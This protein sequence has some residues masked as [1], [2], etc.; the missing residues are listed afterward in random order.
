MFKNLSTKT[1]LLVFPILVVI[2]SIIVAVSY[3]TSMKYIEERTQIAIKTQDSVKILLEARITV[4]Q[5]MQ[6]STQDKKAIVINEFKKLSNQMLTL[7]D[8]FQSDRNKKVADDSIAMINEYVKGFEYISEIM[9]KDKTTNLKDTISH[10]VEVAQKLQ[11]SIISLNSDVNKT[12]EEA[13]NFLST[14]LALIGIISIIVFIGISVFISN[15]IMKSLVNVKEGLLSFFGFLNRKTNNVLTLD[16]GAKDEF[17]DMARLINENINIV[18]DT[19]VKDNELIAEAKMVMVR[20]RN[21]WYSQTIDKSTPNSSLNEFKDELN[22]MISHTKARFVQINEVLAS[23][24]NYDYRPVLNLG[25]DDEAGGVLE[26]MITGINTLQKAITLMLKDNLI[27]GVKLED[28]SKI[29]IENVNKLNT[30]AN[31]AAASLE[32]TAAALEE[33]TSTV[34]NNTNNVM[35]MQDYSA[36]VSDSAKK[37]QG[38]ARNT[39]VAMDEITNQVTNI[40]EAIT[41]IDQIAFQTNILSLNAAVEAA[42]AGEAGKG[43]AVVAQE[44]RNLASRSAEAAKEI[45]NIVEIATQKAQEGKNISDDMIKGYEDLLNNIEK[46]ASMIVEISNASK[47]QQSGISQINDAVTMLDQQTQ[48]NAVIASRTHEIAMDTDNISKHIVDD[49]ME[50]NFDGKNEII[51]QSK[52]VLK[53]DT[54]RNDSN[55]EIEVKNKVTSKKVEP[56]KSKSSNDDEWESF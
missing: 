25:K 24:A 2:I 10:M 6:D 22:E 11:D 46:S 51:S 3:L 41:V 44:V 29:L 47:E 52:K 37:G 31:E 49:V 12:K 42:T 23:Y 9:I 1:K 55:G 7:K 18:K 30:S 26:K 21:G 54:K 8:L 5:F 34:V 19:I 53:T 27:N 39:A 38:M 35:K 56:I 4:Y 45:K 48:Q 16:D 28:S 50:K 13:M 33:I 14:E 36:Q 15:S 43:F 40:N 20:V 32:E 17:G